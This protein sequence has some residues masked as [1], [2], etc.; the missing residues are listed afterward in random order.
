MIFIF[1]FEKSLFFILTKAFISPK[2]CRKKKII[3]VLK[4]IKSDGKEIYNVKKR[5]LF[6]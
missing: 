3:Q 6:K 1:I 5:L 4:C 2:I